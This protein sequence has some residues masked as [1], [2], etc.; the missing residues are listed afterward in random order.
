MMR[1][2]FKIFFASL[3]ALVVFTL[4]AVFFLVSMVGGM[5]SKDRPRVAAKS[6]IVLDLGQH[7]KEQVKQNPFSIFSSDDKDIPGLYDVIR[8]LTRAKTDKNVAGI[9]LIANN[10]PNGFAANE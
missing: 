1:N 9:Y 8:L 10:N 3:L 5:A 6:V 2:F 7:Y 4:L